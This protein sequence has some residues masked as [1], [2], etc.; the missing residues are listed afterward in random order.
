MLQELWPTLTTDTSKFKYP[1]L[2][3]GLHTYQKTQVPC[4]KWWTS[5]MSEVAPEPHVPSRRNLRE[6]PANSTH[7]WLQGSPQTYYVR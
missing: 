6:T 5:C 3:F 1:E 7:Q 4:S 2:H